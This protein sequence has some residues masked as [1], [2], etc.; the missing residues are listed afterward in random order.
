MTM[1][2]VRNVP[3]DEDTAEVIRMAAEDKGISDT[4]LIREILKAWADIYYPRIFWS[5]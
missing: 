3:I 1:P 2:V 5:K 4:L